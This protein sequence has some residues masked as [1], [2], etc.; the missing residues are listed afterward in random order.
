MYSIVYFINATLCG[1][2]AIITKEAGWMNCAVQLWI[3]TL[4]FASKK[5]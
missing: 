5:M 2:V 4:I 3:V 1:V